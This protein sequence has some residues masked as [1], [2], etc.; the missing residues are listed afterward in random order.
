MLGFDNLL[1][2][3]QASSCILSFNHLL[4]LLYEPTLLFGEL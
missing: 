3:S 2:D 4:H 1:P